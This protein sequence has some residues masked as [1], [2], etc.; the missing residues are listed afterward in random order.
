MV[1][2]QD[3]PKVNHCLGIF[4]LSMYTHERDLRD[5]FSRYGPVEDIQV[6]YDH[7][8]GRS[9]GFA[10]VYMRNED[11]AMEVIYH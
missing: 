11:D 5:I 7:Q 2:F 1:V 9:R 3:D 10:F 4:G 6:V 8:T